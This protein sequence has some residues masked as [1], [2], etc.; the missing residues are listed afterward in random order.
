M[1]YDFAAVGAHVS[2]A[3]AFDANADELNTEGSETLSRKTSLLNRGTD[4]SGCS[5]IGPEVALRR[6]ASEAVPRFV[7]RTFLK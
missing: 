3:C 6:F 7:Q 2:I 4:D 1:S 5:S